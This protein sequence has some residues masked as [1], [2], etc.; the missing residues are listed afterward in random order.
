MLV[1]QFKKRRIGMSLKNIRKNKVYNTKRFM[2]KII[3]AYLIGILTIGTVLPTVHSDPARLYNLGSQGQ[4]SSAVN[5]PPV[6]GTPIPTN[7]SANNPI[8]LTWSIPIND[9]ESDQFTWTIQCSNGQMNSGCGQTNG[10]KSLSL[11][12]LMFL[13]T[14]KVWVN[15]T[16]PTGSGLYTR[17]WY[18]FTTKTN[19]INTP[20]VFGTS[21]PANGSTGNLLSLSWSIPISDAEGN[22][23]T[24]TIQCNNGQTNTS[25]G[26][27]NGTKTLVLSGLTFS[28]TYKVWVNATDPTGSGLY[29]RKWYTFTTRGNSPPVFGTSSPANGSTGNLLS[30]S[31]SIPISDAEGNTFSWTIQCSNKQVNSGTAASN[32]TKSLSLSG[33]TYSTT[34]KIWVNATDPTGSGLY[35]RKWY[36]FTTKSLPPMKVIITKPLE[37]TLYIQN[38]ERKS[39]PTNTIIYGP[40]TI[41]ANVTSEIS[42]GRVE[43]YIDGKL[44]DT[45]TTTPY[46]YLW[47]PIIQFHGISLKHT[48]KVIAYD[49]LGNNASDQ[50]NVTKWRF[51]PLPFI[52]GV[53]LASTFFNFK[54]TKVTGLFF[55]VQQSTFTTSFYALHIHYWTTGPFRN[56]GGVINLKSCTGGPIIGPIL[57]V[58]TAPLHNLRY[59]TFTFLGDIQYTSSGF[60]QKITEQPST[61]TLSDLFQNLK[62]CN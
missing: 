35:T 57:S 41:T 42:I 52:T 5:Q 44:K 34:Y 61:T 25:T 22:T 19:L 29:T 58:Q 3:A 17:K 12:G 40:I 46:T 23:F 8:N 1:K 33:L 60:R 55:N 13:T 9:P 4:S 38:E 36:T 32:G 18:T 27:T 50:L 21:S 31:W 56:F 49:T 20:P 30:L 48:I 15:A 24:W 2:D 14:Y 6:F 54:H 59:G 39:L 37:N 51:H 53:G 28:T 11:T 7:G 26:A 10:T 45:V 16:D 47:K 43:F 62:P